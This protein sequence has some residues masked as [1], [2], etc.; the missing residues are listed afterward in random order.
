MPTDSELLERS[1]FTDLI[2]EGRRKP[3]GSVSLHF[4]SNP[5][6]EVGLKIEGD[7]DLSDLQRKIKTTS[8]EELMGLC[9]SKWPEV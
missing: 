2:I 9:W 1:A 3:E 8:S 6:K 7:T 4:N 5:G